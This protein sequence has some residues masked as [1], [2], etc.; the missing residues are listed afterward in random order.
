MPAYKHSNGYTYTAYEVAEQA[1]SA[2]M[3]FDDFIKEK[4]FV[5][6]DAIVDPTLVDFDYRKESKGVLDRVKKVFQWE[7]NNELTFKNYIN[8]AKMGFTDL[9][10]KVWKTAPEYNPLS[11]ILKEIILGINQVTISNKRIDGQ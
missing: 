1:D 2:E 9:M 8:Q 3:S 4:G 11:Y 6:V 7:N 5:K 10:D